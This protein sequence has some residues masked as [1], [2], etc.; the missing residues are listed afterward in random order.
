MSRK[1]SRESEEA[2]LLLGLA[3]FM[4]QHQ[5]NND[6]R[7][8][9]Q[10]DVYRAAGPGSILLISIYSGS[11]SK[12]PL[13]PTI[14]HVNKSIVAAG[15]RIQPDGVE[16]SSNLNS[17]NV[18]DR[19]FPTCLLRVV[20]LKPRVPMLRV[21]LSI[22]PCGIGPSSA[23]YSVHTVWPFSVP[24]SGIGSMYRTFFRVQNPSPLMNIP[25]SIHGLSPSF[26][27]GRPLNING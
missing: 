26:S 25:S 9:L 27:E 16:T 18:S 3:V 22:L 13:N 15:Y 21:H 7:E 5:N 17:P 8:Y 24:G 1:S 14:P 23:V 19:L 11:A 12:L 6:R 20:C 10:V 4:A 2:V